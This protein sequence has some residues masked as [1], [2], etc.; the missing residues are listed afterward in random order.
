MNPERA[1]LHARLD[2]RAK[3]LQELFHQVRREIDNGVFDGTDGGRQWLEQFCIGT[4]VQECAGDFSLGDS[5]GTNND[6]RKLATDHWC[7]SDR[8][9]HDM[10]PLDYIVTNYLE[11]FVD[12][13]NL[14]NDWHKR[15][16]RGGIL[17]VVCRNAD[18]YD[19]IAGPLT[20]P[21]RACC[22]TASTL[23]FYL[24]RAGFEVIL[25]ETCEKELR[26]AARRW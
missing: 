11:T 7:W 3:V 14:L 1:R 18:A 10:G 9:T 21:R 26:I 25:T 16:K 19:T 4:G 6:P 17:A 12:P 15:I 20:N 24:E 13:L 22:F 8:F 5:C 23:R 2:A